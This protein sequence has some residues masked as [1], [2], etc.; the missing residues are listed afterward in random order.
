MRLFCLL[1]LFIGLA[2]GASAAQIHF[3][4]NK[5]STGQRPPG[6]ASFVTGEGNPADW[7]V[8]EESVA[9]T[10]APLLDK[11][12]AT[13]A[14]LPVLSPQSLDT[15]G[16]HFPVLLF[17]NEVFSDFTLTTRFKI[18]GGTDPMAGL[19]FRAQDAN[20]YYVVRARTG[21]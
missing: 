3:D 9:P 15:H 11:A 6:F 8:V 1:S 16:D 2:L 4:F 12:R 18:S 10:L 14:K 20:N 13:L 7:S 19:V 17:T 21:G 5:D